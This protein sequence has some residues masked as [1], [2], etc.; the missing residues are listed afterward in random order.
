M[1]TIEFFFVAAAAALGALVWRGH[2][3]VW[4]AMEPRPRPARLD[5][6]PSVTVIRP[7]KGLDPDLDLNARS[8]LDH[9]YP[10]EV[11]TFFIFDDEFEPGLPIVKKAV[12]EH[13]DS[14]RPGSAAILLCGQPPPDRT[15]KLNAMIQGIRRA[16]GEII[17]FCDS[18]VRTD[19]DALRVLVETL[20]QSERAGS[21]FAPVVVSEPA[22]SLADAVCA[23]LLNGLYTPAACSAIEARG[24]DLP[25][26]LGQ[27]MAFTR[28]SLDAIGRLEDMRGELVDDLHIGVLIERA[29]LR[30]VASAHPIRI[31][32]YGLD[33]RQGVKN[34]LRW[35]TFSRT[36]VPQWS[37]K[38]PILLRAIAVMGSLLAAI[39]LAAAG[40][41]VAAGAFAVLTVATTASVNALHNR[42][43]CAPLRP[44][45]WIAPLATFTV[46]FYVFA[47]IH[48][49][50]SRVDW[51]GRVYALDRSSRLASR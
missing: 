41:G 2:R 20:L 6:Y 44:R 22:T 7:I 5:H 36:G 3:R 32:Q 42:T 23:M 43:G 50:L 16:R 47:R 14:G 11:E 46:V 37:F 45:H 48:L 25:F 1:P 29:G 40:L 13:R 10:G 31:I 27:L 35:M 33:A 17:V 12:A 9:G 28:K 51:R 24:G 49:N 15:G 26:I 30:N 34:V 8:G 18:D 39:A 4:R 19:R 21:A 38:L